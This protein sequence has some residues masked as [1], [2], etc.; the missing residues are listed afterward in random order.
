MPDF[1]IIIKSA[2]LTVQPTPHPNAEADNTME[3][4]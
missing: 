4:G 2:L 3:V 1:V